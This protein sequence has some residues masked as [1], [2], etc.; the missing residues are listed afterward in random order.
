MKLFLSITLLMTSLL[1]HQAEAVHFKNTGMALAPRGSNLPEAR[2]PDGMQM[3]IWVNG[4]VCIAV[5][6][7]GYCCDDG[8]GKR[9]FYILCM[10]S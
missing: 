1:L 2:C 3:C 7:G 5:A 10:I 8:T 6:N 4:R 9:R